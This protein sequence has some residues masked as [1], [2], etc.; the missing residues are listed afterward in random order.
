[1]TAIALDAMGGDHAPGVTVEGALE[2]AAAGV[3]VVLVVDSEV[4][5]HELNRLRA[6]MGVQGGQTNLRIVHAPDQVAMGDHAARE[7][8][9]QRQTSLYVGMELVKSGDA[10]ALVSM[11]NTGA[12]MATAL[13]VATIVATAMGM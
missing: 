1:M 5:G 9:R 13:V 3:E 7:V 2:A 11:G 4:L 10:G 6:R 8:R 12:A